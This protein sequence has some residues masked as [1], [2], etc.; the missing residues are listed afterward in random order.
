MIEHLK[1]IYFELAT[2]ALLPY[3]FRGTRYKND[4]LSHCVKGVLVPAE[5]AASFIYLRLGTPK[6]NRMQTE[7][8]NKE[9]LEVAV[10]KISEL[11]CL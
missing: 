9:Q 1:S 3:R 5:V 11:E 10:T 2:F 7:R 6:S 8:C 4:T